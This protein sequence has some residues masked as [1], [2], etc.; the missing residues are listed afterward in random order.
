MVFRVD[1]NYF[2]GKKDNSTLLFTAICLEIN[3]FG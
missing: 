1:K 2:P 3:F